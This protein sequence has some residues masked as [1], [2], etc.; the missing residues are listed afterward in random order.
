[1]D[2]IRAAVGKILQ[3]PIVKGKVAVVRP[4]VRYKFAD[5]KLEKLSALDKQMLRMGPENTQIIQQKL[6]NFMQDLIASE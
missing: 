1:M 3:A 6:R 5:P 4:S 2:I